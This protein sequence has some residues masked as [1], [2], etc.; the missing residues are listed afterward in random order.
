[1]AYKVPSVSP[2][3]FSFL[4]LGKRACLV[5][6]WMWIRLL[7]R[8]YGINYGRRNNALLPRL[9]H[10]KVAHCGFFCGGPSFPLEAENTQGALVLKAHVATWLQEWRFQPSIMPVS[11][12]RSSSSCPAQVVPEYISLFQ[13]D[14]NLHRGPRLTPRGLVILGFHSLR[15]CVR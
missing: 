12:P 6:P 1:M 14:Y 10:T 13:P 15:Q 2:R 4:T 9:S 11:H 3:F 8:F 5:H 7:T